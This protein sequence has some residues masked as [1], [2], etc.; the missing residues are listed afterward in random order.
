[1]SLC[2]VA[3]TPF[4]IQGD[5]INSTNL[6]IVVFLFSTVQYILILILGA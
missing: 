5:D 2:K 3:D 6:C 4:H 1:M